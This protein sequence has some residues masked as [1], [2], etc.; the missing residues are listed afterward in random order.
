MDNLIFE[1]SGTNPNVTYYS[2]EN[3]KDLTTWQ[4][5]GFDI[6][7]ELY[8]SLWYINENINDGYPIIATFVNE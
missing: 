3:L 8:S 1:G 4:D 6:S 2:D 7:T 5:L